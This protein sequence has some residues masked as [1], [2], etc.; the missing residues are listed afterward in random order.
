MG[1]STQGPAGSIQALILRHSL[2]VYRL[3]Y[4][5]AGNR[6]DAD[7]IFQEV[8]LRCLKAQPAFRDEVHERAFLIRVTVNLSRNFLKSA[9]RRHTVPLC[10][11]AGYMQDACLMEEHADLTAALDALPKKS[12][13]ILHLHY[14]ENM[15]AEEIAKALSM[16]A[17]S[18]RVELSRSRRKLKTKLSGEEA[19]SHV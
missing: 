6:H 8:F 11:Q 15:T 5:R 18:V 16:P 9:W 7:D 3:A 13:T 1:E 19:L 17:S 4:V 10:E 12:R 14:F 2:L